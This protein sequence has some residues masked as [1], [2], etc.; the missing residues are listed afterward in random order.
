MYNWQKVL[1]K[2]AFLL[3]PRLPKTISMPFGMRNAP[4]TNLCKK[5]VT[6]STARRHLGLVYLDDVSVISWFSE[7]HTGPVCNASTLPSNAKSLQ[8]TELEICRFFANAIDFSGHII[9]S[10]QMKVA[11]ETTDANYE[12][13][14]HTILKKVPFS[15]WLCNT[16]RWLVRNVVGWPS[17]S[18][19]SNER[20]VL[21][22]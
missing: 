21:Q 14:L 13:L 7:K 22:N 10:S 11:F 2:V 1:N 8:A 6:L 15:L 20:L 18:F 19:F 3:H 9:H 12:L 5:D 16:F 4:S 17:H